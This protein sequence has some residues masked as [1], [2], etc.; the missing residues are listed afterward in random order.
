[1]AGRLIFLG[2]GAVLMY[3]LDPETGRKR[4][5]DL[6][7]QVE[8]T[9]RRIQ[10]ARDV[11]LRDATNRTHGALTETSHWLQTRNEQLR[12]R[13]RSSRPPAHWSPSQRAVVGA[14]GT[15]LATWGY[16]R[17][18]VKGVAMVAL[19]G[20]LLARAATDKP[21]GAL[22]HG[23]GF[24]VEKTI[25]IRKPVEEVFAYWR[26]LQNLPIWMSHVREVRYLGGDRYHWVVDGPAGAPVEWNSELLNVIENRE[27]TWRSVEGS[28]V[29]HT[30]RIRFEPVGNGT[31]VLVQLHY[32]P[33][34]GLLGHLVAKAFH[35]DPKS[36]MDDDLGRLKAML[37]TGTLPSGSAVDR[38]GEAL[39]GT[40]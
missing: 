26:N 2:A 9:G 12:N 15:G 18:G 22:A 32:T 24:N 4:R 3:L 17:G 5:N 29:E 39:G 25:H 33:P 23:S 6:R 27:M 19:G 14:L 40:L 10:H 30:G 28:T 7:N 35:A 20:G 34:G 21:L 37:E 31:H 13:P 8:A 16:L 38:R 36:E 11:V 1:M